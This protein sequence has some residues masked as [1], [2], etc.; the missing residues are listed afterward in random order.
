MLGGAQGQNNFFPG[1]DRSNQ[2]SGSDASKS[3]M[4]G[5]DKFI[6][7]NLQHVKH[8]NGL[9]ALAATSPFKIVD[10]KPVLHPATQVQDSMVFTPTR[11]GPSKIADREDKQAA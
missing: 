4:R 7:P 3:S 9:D 10:D 6:I 1:R 5:Y 2:K 8:G 11:G